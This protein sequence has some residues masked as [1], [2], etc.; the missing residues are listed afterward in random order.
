MQEDSRATVKNCKWE[1]V[2]VKPIILPHQTISEQANKQNWDQIKEVKRPHIPRHLDII[3]M[4]LWR[5]KRH[6]SENIS[7]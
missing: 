3:N 1:N 5:L 2:C 6:G 7:G 4:R